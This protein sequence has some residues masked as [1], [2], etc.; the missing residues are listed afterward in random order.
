MENA[1]SFAE[2][3][4][5]SHLLQEAINPWRETQ[6]GEPTGRSGQVVWRTLK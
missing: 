6:T 2:L 1:T 3:L 4:A 5:P